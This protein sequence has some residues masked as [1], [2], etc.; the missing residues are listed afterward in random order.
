MPWT[1]ICDGKELDGETYETPIICL[2]DK[3]ENHSLEIE[4]SAGAGSVAI[5]P[6]TSISGKSWKNEGVVVTGFGTGSGGD[7]DGIE[8]V[9]LLLSP[10]E[11]IYFKVVA[12]GAAT[13][14][15]WFTQK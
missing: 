10:A 14:A 5:T 12:T 4:V 3:L 15:L 9:D 8:I 11:S 13:I 7:S 6:Y 1:A 2:R